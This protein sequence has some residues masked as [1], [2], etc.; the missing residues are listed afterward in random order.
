MLTWKAC[1]EKIKKIVP[2]VELYQV[3]KLK[4]KASLKKLMNVLD[5]RRKQKIKVYYCLREV[6]KTL[7]G[8]PF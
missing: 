1:I 2:Y 3:I 6:L 7:F 8:V 4:N 5:T